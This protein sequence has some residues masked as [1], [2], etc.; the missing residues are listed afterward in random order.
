M[1]QGGFSSRCLGPRLSVSQ[2]MEHLLDS[3]LKQGNKDKWE[4]RAKLNATKIKPRKSSRGPAYDDQIQIRRRVRDNG[5]G[6]QEG[7]RADWCWT[8]QRR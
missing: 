4:S 2:A 1:I 6:V 7:K 5:D 8:N 3:R